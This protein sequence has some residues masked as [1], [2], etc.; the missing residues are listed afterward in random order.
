MRR[1][2]R[3]ALKSLDK[4]GSERLHALIGELVNENEQLEMV[5]SSIPGAVLVAG[6]DHR[7]VMVNK[8]ALRLLPVSE[9]EASEKL[10]W[11]VF[12]SPEM[13]GYVREAL[14]GNKSAEMKDFSCERS[15]LNLIISC[16][17]LPLLEGKS[18]VGA[19]VYMEDVTIIRSEQARLRRA[20]S[21][22]SLTNM[23]AGVAHEIK[24]PLASMS[25]HLQLMK[26]QLGS[27]EVDT[28]ELLEYLGIVEEETERLNSIVSDYLLA[29]RSGNLQRSMS[30][31]NDIISELLQFLCFEMKELRVIVVEKLD[32]NLPLVPL[33]EASMKQA[34]LNLV[35]NAMEAMPNGGKIELE[36]SRDADRIYLGV[37]DSGQG[38]P[39]E[40]AGKIFEPYFTT[41]STGSGLGLTIVYKVVREHGGDIEVNSTPGRGTAFQVTLPIPQREPKLI[42]DKA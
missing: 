8:P 26:R 35:K 17:V 37:R 21:L 31:L 10:A 12:Y 33:D 9:E 4:L 20:E 23:A 40:I 6:S 27:C 36:T 5:L 22:A 16:G 3:R 42:E 24:N 25:I 15:G 29:V 18:I 14:E 7:I 2:V 19:M 1:L 30:S 28:E 13:S 34:I 41:R 32:K 38:I 39:E 11:E